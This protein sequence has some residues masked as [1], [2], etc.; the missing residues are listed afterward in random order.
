MKPT[1]YIGN[2]NYSSW[3]MRGWLPL[4]KAGIDFNEVV[5]PLDTPGFKEKISNVSPTRTVPALHAEGVEIGESLAIAEWVAEQAPDLWPR[6]PGARLE[7]RSA[8]ALMHSGFRNLRQACPMN[9]KFRDCKT[10][11]AALEDAAWVDKLWTQWLEKSG[12]PFLFG[13]WSIADAFYAPVVSRF[14]TYSLPRSATSQTYLDTMEAEPAFAQWKKV[15]LE[16][17]WALPKWD[18]LCQPK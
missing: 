11:E 16:E 7:A 1:I 17:E 4:K 15:G 3:S 2:K 6:D 8:A 13:D 10:P 12:G 18:D 5:I 9:M 14:V